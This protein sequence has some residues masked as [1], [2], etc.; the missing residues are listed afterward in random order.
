MVEL[1][2]SLATEVRL[3]VA[4]V[5]ALELEVSTLRRLP[6]KQN[7][8]FAD[9]SSLERQP[10]ETFAEF[11]AMLKATDKDLEEL[12]AERQLGPVLARVLLRALDTCPGTAPAAARRGKLWIHCST[13]WEAARDEDL[14]DVVT[15]LRRSLLAVFQAWSE[16]NTAL[17]EDDRRNVEYYT[18]L[19]LVMGGEQMASLVRRRLARTAPWPGLD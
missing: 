1:D 8:S 5:T 13:G 4:R 16:R 15:S 14:V 7:A 9:L 10:I 19:R 3:L 11:A 6:R 18:R 17:L 12:A 2:H